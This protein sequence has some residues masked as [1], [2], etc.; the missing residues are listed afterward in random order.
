MES[1]EFHDPTHKFFTQFVS[2]VSYDPQA[3]CPEWLGFL[4]SIWSDHPD[5][6][7]CLQQWFGY[8]LTT[9]TDLQKMLLIHGP[10]RSGKG[11]INGVI[12][13]V[14][15]TGVKALD[16][17][18]LGTTFGM[19]NVGESRLMS[20]A[21]VRSG[22]LDVGAKE[23]LLQLIACDP[24]K[25]EKKFQSSYTAV[26]VCKVMGFC[27]EIPEFL[28]ESNALL[29]RYILLGMYREFQGREDLDLP[30]RLA[31]ELPGILNWAVE[32][33]N[34]LQLFGRIEEPANQQTVRQLLTPLTSPVATWAEACVVVD[35]EGRVSFEDAYESYNAFC[36][37]EFDG[38]G[39]VDKRVFG[40]KL[41]AQFPEL[42][43]Y[44]EAT[45]DRG[46]GFT[47]IVL[48]DGPRG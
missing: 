48:E 40:K 30:K 11:V 12:K 5:H 19:Q 34:K 45:G 21:D 29:N 43:Q 33:Y 20:I 35:P 23:Q 47:G 2:P 28:D 41:K 38:G 27:N 37:S 14:L 6:I 44:R 42:G 46:R 18:K 13:L 32:G 31:K 4:D 8:C 22:K 15:G 36:E 17:R 3:E 9:R 1:N 26:P 25:V 16:I 24:V 7:E 39:Y 10:S